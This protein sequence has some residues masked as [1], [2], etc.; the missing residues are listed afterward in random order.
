[1]AKKSELTLEELTAQKLRRSNGWTRFW[2]IVLAFVLVGGVAFFANNQAKKANEAAEAEASSLA[3]EYANSNSGG[4][5]WNDGSA[6]GGDSAAAGDANAPASSEAEEAVKAINAATAEAAKASYS[7]TRKC[8]FTRAIDVGSATET[9]NGIIHRVD[10]NADLNSVVGGFIGRGDK[11]ATYSAGA[12]AKETFGN[13]NY[14][15]KATQLKASD[16]QE[17]KVDGSTYTFK[18]ANADN[19]QKDGSTALN[20]LTDDF[21]TQ[22]EVADGIKDALGSLSFLLSVKSADV[23][24]T[25][26]EVTVVLKDGKLES[27]HYY[28]LMDVKKLELSVATGTGAG[29]VD[30]TYNNFVY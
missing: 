2:A 22:Q 16:L 25:D 8:D 29:Y 19:A 14:A 27:L 11:Q 26:I 30:A 20:R 17:L 21:I 18:L 28:Y 12:D 4:Q 1:M 15:L 24:F 10:S 3:A 7:W 13:A 5:S 9:L 23:S 6:S